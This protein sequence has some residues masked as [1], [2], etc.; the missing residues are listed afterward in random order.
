MYTLYVESRRVTRQQRVWP[1]T[2]YAQ[3]QNALGWGDPFQERTRTCRQTDRQTDVLLQQLQND[4]RAQG[5]WNKHAL[6]NRLRHLLSK[7]DRTLLT[8]ESSC[9][10]RRCS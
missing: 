5:F 8:A 10:C 4:L 9:G 1:S 7:A 6:Q 2:R 3:D